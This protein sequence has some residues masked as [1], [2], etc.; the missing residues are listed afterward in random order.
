MDG[1][2]SGLSNSDKRLV[3]LA[4]LNLKRVLPQFV[5]DR[6]MSTLKVL[7]AKVR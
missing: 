3:V 4:I 7:E 2:G 5:S 6:S 1:T